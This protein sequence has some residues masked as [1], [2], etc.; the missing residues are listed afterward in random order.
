M[1]GVLLCCSIYEA[2]R[3][4]PPDWGPLKG[5]PWVGSYPVV[6]CVRHLFISIVQLPVLVYGEREAM[7]MAPSPTC[8]S[9]VSPCFPTGI[10]HHDL[11]PHIPSIPLSAVNS[12]SHPEVPPQ[13][14]NSSSQPLRLPEDLCP[15][16]GVYGCGKDCLILIPFRLS[17]I[18]CFILSLKCFSSDSDY[19]PDVRIALLLQFPH[20]LRA[21]PVLLTL[22][23]FPLVPL[24]Y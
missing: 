21:G 1:P 2:H 20:P 7:V 22:L 24:C 14:L 19:C 17:Q 3:E 11:L 15:V 23:L 12:S 18:S 9:A 16:W 10:S 8:D 4:G 13:S 5:H 6:Q